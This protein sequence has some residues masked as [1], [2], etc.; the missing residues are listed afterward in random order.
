MPELA[1]TDADTILRGE[2]ADLLAKGL[3]TDVMPRPEDSNACNE[4]VALLA[5][6]A[7]TLER[8]LVVGGFT[9]H[10]IDVEGME[11]AC[12]TC[13]YYLVHRNFCDLPEL[14]LPV[15]AQWSCKLWRI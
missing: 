2:I 14:M 5:N 15:E 9:D 12:E 3:K 13:M 4:I 1:Q 10:P 11:Q 6:G 8:K 7:G